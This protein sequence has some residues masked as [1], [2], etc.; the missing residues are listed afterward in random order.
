MHQ[1]H[2][3]ATGDMVKCFIMLLMIISTVTEFVVTL[4]FVIQVELE[5]LDPETEKMKRARYTVSACC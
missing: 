4:T 1:Y 2:Y 5:N 3:A